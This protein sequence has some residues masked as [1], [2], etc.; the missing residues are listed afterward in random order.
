MKRTLNRRALLGGALVLLIG[1]ACSDDDADVLGSGDLTDNV[2]APDDVNGD[3]EQVTTPGE[4]DTTDVGEPEAPAQY[5]V[6]GFTFTDMGQVS[7]MAVVD[8]L[9]PGT[10]VNLSSA[11]T[12]QWGSFAPSPDRDGVVYIG[13]GESPTLVKYRVGVDGSIEQLG[14]LSFA[15]EGLTAAAGVR[16]AI[17]FVSATKA[18]FIDATTQ[19]AI[20]WNPDV[21][22]VAGSI[23]MSGLGEEGLSVGGNF[24]HRVDDRL[25]LSVRYFRE[26]DS[27]EQ[28]GRIAIIDTTTDTVSYDSQTACGNLAWSVVSSAGD[29]YFVS[30]T[31]QAVAVAAGTAGDPASPPCMVRMRRGSDGFD[32]D[33]YVDLQGLTGR[34]AG[35]LTQ[36]VG[37]TAYL[38]VRRDDADPIT[39]EN[40]PMANRLPDWEYHALTLGDEAGSLSRVAGMDAGAAYGL[41]F[42]AV[43]GAAT[44]PTPH[45]VLV[46]GDFSQGTFFDV[47]D[48]GEF[49]EALTA[50]GFPAAAARLR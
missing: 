6:F 29:V 23:D 46:A 20:I 32:E 1:S 12:G 40:A 27:A 50:P 8:S 17:H 49:K 22:E 13:D 21:M 25:I 33:Y 7:Y 16:N 24:V 31:A 18:Y 10:Q 28:L 42:E 44:E 34:E 14:E 41:S 48:P 5:A 11:L 45:I 36:G 2:G 43:V 4:N 9:D 3:G 47:S 39:K 26:D 15:N 35:G 37:D 19:Q 30:H 38:L